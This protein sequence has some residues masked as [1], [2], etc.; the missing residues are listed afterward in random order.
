MQE[1]ILE[2]HRQLEATRQSELDATRQN[3]SEPLADFHSPDVVAVEDLLNW[4]ESATSDDESSANLLNS[5]EQLSLQVAIARRSAAS[6]ATESVIA[7]QRAD[8][9]RYLAPEGQTDSDAPPSDL[10]ESS[11]RAASQSERRA[12]VAQACV[13]ALES[14]QQL[15]TIQSQGESDENRAAE[16]E[17]ANMQLATARAQVE[18]AVTAWHDASHDGEYSAFGP[19]YP[20]TSTGR[21]AAL[22]RWLTH[23]DHPLTARVAINHIWLRHFHVPLAAD[24]ADFGR[25]GALPTHPELLDWLANL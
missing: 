2:E 21:R 11:I 20:K 17:T 12:T 15:A 7:R 23:P 6:A 19:T 22:A 4:L 18:Q 1:A 9:Q 3:L 14:L 10:V 24:V 8:R 25:N 13:A 5:S 16:L